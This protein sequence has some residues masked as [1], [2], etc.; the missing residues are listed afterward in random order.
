MVLSRKPRAILNKE[1]IAVWR[2]DVTVSSLGHTSFC[3]SR[4]GPFLNL[5]AL[6]SESV[7]GGF[8]LGLPRPPSNSLGPSWSHHVT[9][10]YNFN[11]V[12]SSILLTCSHPMNSHH[13]AATR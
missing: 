4:A 2:R 7:A 6:P 12:A 10:D 9:F 13:A 8:L 11:S 3:G 5:A 1:L